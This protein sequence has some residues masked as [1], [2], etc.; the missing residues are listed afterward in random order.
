MNLLTCLP[1][2]LLNGPMPIPA[3]ACSAAPELELPSAHSFG[4]ELQSSHICPAPAS[5]MLARYTS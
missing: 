5:G 1:A 2:R 4:Y 3:L